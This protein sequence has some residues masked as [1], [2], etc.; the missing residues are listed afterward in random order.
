MKVIMDVPENT[1]PYKCGERKMACILDGRSLKRCV[2]FFE[3]QEELDAFLE[4]NSDYETP[5]AIEK[6]KNES[7]ETQ[8]LTYRDFKLGFHFK[9]ESFRIK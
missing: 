3:T 8:I 9:N 5:L 2:N 1:V 7:G 4:E 6:K